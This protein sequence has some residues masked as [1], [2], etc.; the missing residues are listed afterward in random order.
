[1][2]PQIKCRSLSLR[3]G[4][5]PLVADVCRSRFLSLRHYVSSLH[6]YGTTGETDLHRSSSF[7][8]VAP[9]T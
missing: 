8:Y 9:S 7:F 5:E 2:W 4:V 6:N 3:G 1:M